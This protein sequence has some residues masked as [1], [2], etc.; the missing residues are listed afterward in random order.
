MTKK[1]QQFS[2]DARAALLAK[3]KVEFQENEAWNESMHQL[4]RKAYAGEDLR[5]DKI[6]RGN[7]TTMTKMLS[8]TLTALESFN[9]NVPSWYE[10][11][12]YP[13][14]PATKKCI[15]G[16]LAEVR[17]RASAMDAAQNPPF[18]RAGGRPRVFPE[19]VEKYI[20]ELIESGLAPTTAKKLIHEEFKSLSSV[21]EVKANL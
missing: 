20:N 11:N 10:D 16:V 2:A 1:K 3:F 19:Y 5:A 21:S 4:A 12:V 7:L 13:F 14:E 17:H 18:R 6:A 9:S 15:E 8:S